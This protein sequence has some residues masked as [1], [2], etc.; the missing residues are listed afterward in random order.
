MKNCPVQKIY[1]LTKLKNLFILTIFLFSIIITSNAQINWGIKGGLNY[2][3]NGDLISESEN[4]IVNPDSNTG[5]H[6]GVFATTSG[7]IFIRPEL[8]FTHTKSIYEANGLKAD[9]KMDKI[10]LPIL[11]G[12]KIIGPL[13]FFIG[14]SLQYIISTDL[15]NTDLADVEKDITVGGVVGV[16]VQLGNLGVDIKYERG[17]SSNEAEFIGITAIGRIDTRPKQIIASVSYKF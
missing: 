14:P 8:V 15:E 9:F 5:Y 4:I 7:K 17:F 6:F 3:S 12:L 2:N 1:K 16:G 10:D 11:V 13:N